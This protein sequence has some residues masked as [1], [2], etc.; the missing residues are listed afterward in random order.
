MS[1]AWSVPLQRSARQPAAPSSVSRGWLVAMMRLQCEM[2]WSWPAARAALSFSLYSISCSKDKVVYTKG[3]RSQM[4]SPSGEKTGH[5]SE[6]QHEQ[7]ETT[8]AYAC[9]LREQPARARPARLAAKTTHETTAAMP[10]QGRQ[11]RSGSP[12]S[13]RPRQLDRKLIHVTSSGKKERKRR[14]AGA[15]PLPA[16]SLR[17]GRDHDRSRGTRTP[18]S[19]GHVDAPQHRRPAFECGGDCPAIMAGARTSV[20]SDLSPFGASGSTAI[21]IPPR[22]ACRARC[23]RVR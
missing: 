9:F 14:E 7:R 16:K 13:P 2:D 20:L 3:M 8:P 4:T 11:L 1:P 10:R 12:D 15:R 19:T 17:R 21:A 18:A 22:L 5:N 6:R 23:W